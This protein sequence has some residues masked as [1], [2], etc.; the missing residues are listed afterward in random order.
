MERWHLYPR[1]EFIGS[2][3]M[4]VTSRLPV[5]SPGM[6]EVGERLETRAVRGDTVSST[7]TSCMARQVKT[8]TSKYTLSDGLQAM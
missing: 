1:L 6:C 5:F 4:M 3:F 2:C 8:N 7:R